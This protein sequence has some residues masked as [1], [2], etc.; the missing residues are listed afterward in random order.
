MTFPVAL[1]DWLPWWVPLILIVPCLLYGLAFLVMPFAV[2]GVKARL[3]AIDVRLDE[4]QGEIRSLSLRL[5]EPSVGSRGGAA[6]PIDPA[7]RTPIPPAHRPV[8]VTPRQAPSVRGRA[9]PRL[10]WPQ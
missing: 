6:K 1:P 5:Q 9:E 8:S 7:M 4:I 10:N 2:L 3:D